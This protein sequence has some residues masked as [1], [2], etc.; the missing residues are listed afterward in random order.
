MSKKELQFRISS[1]LKDIIGRD[2]ITDD[3]IAIF[4]LVKNSFD[5]YATRVDIHFKNIKTE[6]PKIIIIDNGKGMNYDDLIKKWLFVAYSAKKEG[7]EDKNFDYRD[8]IFSNKPFAGAKGIGRF[9]CDRLGRYLYLETTKLE[10]NPK[11]EVI[12]TNWENFEDN[13][14]DQFID[15]G[16][17][18]ET[19]SGSDYGLKHGVVLEITG[20]RSKWDRKKLL[21][22][23]NSLSKLINPVKDQQALDFR[24]YMHAKELI[25]EDNKY[26]EYYKKVNGEVQNFI[27]ETLGLKTTKI[28]TIISKEHLKTQLFDGGTL[29]YEIVEPNNFKSLKDITF[30]LYYLNKSAKLTFARRMG[31]ASKVYGHVFL[32]KN[33]FRIYP[34]GEP[35]EDP[36]KI[37][38]RKSRKRNSRLGTG[39]LIGRIEIFGDNE[40][41]RE[42][43]SRGD[44]L[45]QNDSYNQL[46][47]CFFYILEKLEKYVVHVQRWGLSIEDS[48]EVLT[49]SRAIDLIAELTNTHDLIDFKVPDNFLNLLEVSQANSVETVIKSLNKIAQLKEDNKLLDIT[50]QATIKL[51]ELQEARKEAEKIAEEESKKA[52]RAT[53]RLRQK[54][55]E[56]LFLKSIN[57]S[58]YNEVISL[59][60]HVGIYAGTIEN[61]LKG[62][63]LRIQNDIPLSKEELY[64]I[65]KVIGF[66][67]KKIL[68]ITAFATKANFN[69]KTETKEVDLNNYFNEY[70]ENIIPT[71]V[72]KK[73]EIEFIDEYRDIFIIKVKP[74]EINIVI[75][76]LISNARKAGANK[77]SIITSK[78]NNDDGFTVKFIDNGVGI[79]L[80]DL[81]K[82]YNIGFTTTDGSGLGLYHSR[83]IIRDIGGKITVENNK[84]SK[85]VAFTLKFKQ[86]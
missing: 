49:K 11:T 70:I 37:D 51:K 62:I 7:T 4:E 75:D 10:E 82:I 43:S 57:T 28:Y 5:A 86:K 14:H 23:K 12:L 29:I 78:D 18:H 27:F 83:K 71:I 72:D 13:P 20:L 22:L 19:K 79:E 81:S 21:N 25:E 26:E 41:F 6:N 32:Y 69:L 84:D 17:L 34:F 15:I 59:L 33:N 8:R 67:S 9:S 24:I 30:T 74:I 47:E 3:Y 54:I 56:N 85:G 58:D 55:S 36:M 39:E 50:H 16:V 31:V 42:T 77:L 35:F 40:E 68:N 44:G 76:N 53:R 46:V 45:I 65:I 61:H 80:D 52:D 66:E 73:L 64:D 48:K 2:L 38:V 60:H 1:S 63:S